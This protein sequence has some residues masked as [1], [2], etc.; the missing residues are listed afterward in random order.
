MITKTE[1]KL[2]DQ[3]VTPHGKW[4]VPFVWSCN[5]VR[6]ARRQGRISDNYLMK[7]LLDVRHCLSLSILTTWTWVSWCLVKQR[8]MELVVTTAAIS[9]AKLQS[10]HHHQ[11]TNIQFFTG[12]LPFLSPNQQCQSSEGKISHSMNLLTPSL[13]ATVCSFYSLYS[14]L[15]VYPVKPPFLHMPH[16]I[17]V[18]QTLWW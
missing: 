18:N 11:Q 16:W 13:P 2:L 12:W 9:R 17:T 5:L 1:I 10:N 15:A 4:W 3:V 6:A 14:G 7:S 8:M